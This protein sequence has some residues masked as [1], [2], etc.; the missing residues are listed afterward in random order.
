MGRIFRIKLAVL[1]LLAMASSMLPAAAAE[2]TGTGD[3]FVLNGI[4]ETT[5][6]V[7]VNDRMVGDDV[8]P[9][10]VVGALPL[11]EG[12]YRVRAVGADGATLLEQDFQVA[13]GQSIDAVVHLDSQASPQPVLTLF[14][15]DLTPVGSGMLRVAIA[16]TASVPPADIRVEGQVL[17]ANVANGEGATAEV[18]GGSYSVDVVPTGTDG[19]PILGPA[20]FD[21][22]PGTLTRVFAIGRPPAQQMQAIVQTLS[23][24][25]GGAAEP[26]RVES[27]SGGAAADPSVPTAMVAVA[28]AGIVVLGASALGRALRS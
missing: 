18:P 7:F 25:A 22:A 11:A 17:F 3:I 26:Q 4:P 5:I 28:V 14:P 15:N 27:G 2:S 23:L 8:G 21:L 6:D 20:S 13:G 16:H 24:P 19:P 10:A 12:T 9:T 1:F